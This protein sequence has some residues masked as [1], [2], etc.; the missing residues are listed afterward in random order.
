MG[1]AVDALLH[2]AQIAEQ[3]CTAYDA[4]SS[5][6][7][8]WLGLLMGSLAQKG[9]DKLTFVVSEPIASFGL[10]VEQLVAESTGKQGRGILPV[11]EEP[12]GD[13]DV[14][15][16]DRLFAYLRNA[17]EPDADAD[18][19]IEALGKAGQPTVTLSV[20]G[21]LD[22]GR[23]FFFAEFATAVSGWVLGIN[24]VQPAQRP[25]GQGQHRQG[26]RGLHE[27]G[28]AA[29]ARRRR[30]RR[31]ARAA[32]RGRA[33]ALRRDHGLRQPVARV[34]RGRPSA[35]APRSATAPRPPPRSATAR[36]SCT[37]R[38]SSTRAGRRSACSCS[39][40]TTATRTS[41]SP[42]PPTRSGRSRTRRP[43]AT[44]RR[45]ATTACPAERVRL[46][47]DPAAALDALRERI[48]GLL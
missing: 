44:C 17:D 3:N 31:A 25:G 27:G 22:L 10:W 12:L 18:A 14:Y 32:R 21:A 26:A 2:R 30:R 20:H 8:L 7:G 37:R 46:E 48:E 19:K 29:G 39:S 16:D 36:A 28:Q 5:N 23:I 15:G 13:P 40:C 42:A 11:A 24:A 1:I 9:R 34:R 4:S 35:C 38:A 33:A 43:R 6:S 45:C 47:G 41:R